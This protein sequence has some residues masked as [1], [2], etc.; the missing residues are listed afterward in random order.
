MGHIQESVL[1]SIILSDCFLNRCA[2]HQNPLH[3]SFPPEVDEEALMS[4]A[5][6][7]SKAVME[8]DLS[9]VRPNTDLTVQ[10]Q[11]RKE[12][13]SFLIGFINDNGVLTKV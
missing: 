1:L 11:G 6:Q 12:R 3:F 10:M 7:L 5:E 4:G 2:V 13:L 9:I 8:S